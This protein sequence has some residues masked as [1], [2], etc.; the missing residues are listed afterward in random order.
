MEHG[1]F[2]IVMSFLDQS[3]NYTLGFECGMIWELLRSG[4]P[5]ESIT[6]HASNV[7]QLHR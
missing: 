5:A 3:E 6:V 2:G 1:T 4:V 7:Q